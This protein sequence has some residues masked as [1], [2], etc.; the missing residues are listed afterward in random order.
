MRGL[1]EAAFPMQ[2]RD[3]YA[4]ERHR[5]AAGLKVYGRCSRYMGWI[6][7]NLAAKAT[8][9]HRVIVARRIDDKPKAARDAHDMNVHLIEFEMKIGATAVCGLKESRKAAA[10][11]SKLRRSR[12]HVMLS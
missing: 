12:L 8:R 3:K 2:C 4:R 6:R 7:K 11:H 1:P 5:V 9:M 10:K